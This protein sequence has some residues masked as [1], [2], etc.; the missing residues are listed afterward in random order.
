MNKLYR[1]IKRGEELLRS[2]AVAHVTV[3]SYYNPQHVSPVIVLVY[4]NPQHVSH[5]IVLIYYNPQDQSLKI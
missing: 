4:Y 3:L 1:P 2:T 5:V